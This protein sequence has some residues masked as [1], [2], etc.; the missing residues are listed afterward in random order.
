[1]KTVKT[2][3]TVSM[4]F[5]MVSCAGNSRIY[6]SEEIYSF[7]GKKK[8]REPVTQIIVKKSGSDNLEA[9][10]T[11]PLIPAYVIRG[12]TIFDGGKN[13]TIMLE[14]VTILS[15]WPNGW[16]HGEQEASGIIELTRSDNIW[17]CTVKEKPEFWEITGGEIRYYDDYFRKDNGLQKVK[18]RLERISAVCSHMH[19]ERLFPPV[20]GSTGKDTNYGRGMDKIIKPY[21]FPELSGAKSMLPQYKD[22][23]GDGR[24]HYIYGADIRWR[25]DYTEI[26]FPDFLRAIRNSGTMWRDYEEAPE[27]FMSIYNMDYYF[28]NI[29]ENSEFKSDKKERH[30]K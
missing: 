16:T 2:A 23:E 1:M 17:H 3:I 5:L 8:G 26:M 4:I 7:V 15:G 27:L 6:R 10:I 13:V 9:E 14:S 11:S 22:K 29:L 20:L 12:E 19:E 18:S 28:R 30:E 24:E 25:K 21:L